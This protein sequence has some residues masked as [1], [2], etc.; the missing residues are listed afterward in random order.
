MSGLLHDLPAA[1]AARH[2]GAPAVLDGDRTLS[3]GDLDAGANRVARAL[4]E[5]GI[6][7]GDRV[8]LYL[9]KSADPASG[10]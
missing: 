4:A 3:Y 9:E 5:A 6:G 8:G 1:A 7:P 10:L 2:P